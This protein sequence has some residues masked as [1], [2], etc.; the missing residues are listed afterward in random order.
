M[1]AEWGTRGDTGA[2]NARVRPV[3]VT[4][5]RTAGGVALARVALACAFAAGLVANRTDG[6][7][8][9]ELPPLLQP[10]GESGSMLSALLHAWNEEVWARGEEDTHTRIGPQRSVV[11]AAGF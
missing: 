3:A 6:A 9:L 7:A 8:T 1:Q 4:L 2:A 5:Q 10:C 11:Q